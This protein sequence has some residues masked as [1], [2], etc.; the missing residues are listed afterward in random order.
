MKHARLQGISTSISSSGSPTA[1]SII[2]YPG[3]YDCSYCLVQV[4]DTTN[5]RYQLSE[6]V[7]LE[8]DQTDESYWRNLY[9]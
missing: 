6:I 7:L 4:A 5:N 9:C 8:L 2:E 3:D 1:T